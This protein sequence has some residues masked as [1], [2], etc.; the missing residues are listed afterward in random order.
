MCHLKKKNFKRGGRYISM[1]TARTRKKLPKGPIKK[2][3]DDN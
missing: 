1:A 2:V 3:S